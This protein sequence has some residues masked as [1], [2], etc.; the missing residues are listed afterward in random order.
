M[1]RKKKKRV[2]IFCG[3]Y[4]PH[5]GGSESHAREFNLYLDELEKYKIT[6]F[7][8][9]LPKDIKGENFY[10][11]E[12]IRE[13]RCP[14]FELIS[15]YPFPKLWSFNFWK[16][17]IKLFQEDFDLVIS[18]I[19]FFPTSLMALVFAKIKKTPWV[20]IEHSSDFVKLESRW[21]SLLA[22]FYD[23]TAGW[24]VFNFSDLNISI[25]EAVK[26]FIEKFNKRETPVIYRGLELNN[27][28]GDESNFLKKVEPELKG[29][30]LIVSVARLYKWKGI[31]RGVEAIQ[32]LSSKWKNKVVYIVVGD[33]EDK[34]RLE[35][36]ACGYESIIFT[37]F[38]NKKEVLSILERADIY[39][40]TSFPGGGLSTSLLE[41][42]LK[43]C[44]VVA[45]PHEGA[46]EV[47]DQKTGILLD[48]NFTVKDLVKNVQFLCENDKIR[49]ELGILARE[50]VK[51]NFNWNQ[52]IV[53]YDKIFTNL[54]KKKA[55]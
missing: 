36:K 41:A 35:K 23:K 39:L 33:G 37:G 4:P 50:K 31:E 18:R 55:K 20:H 45:S 2:L 21:K 1:S 32:Q 48:E 7:T 30:I 54:L 28:K 42:M 16:K 29:K 52:S 8:S 17:W 9:D 26:K 24:L 6:V 44:A 53:E 43:K 11:D 22:K 49:K 3:Y 25:S 38:L 13:I 34:R 40:H 14:A 47:V 27:K 5:I 51:K 15:N 46:R 10:N 19:R 12:K